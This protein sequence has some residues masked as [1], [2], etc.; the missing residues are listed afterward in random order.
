LTPKI[1]F[2]KDDIIQAGLD[3]IESGG[4]ENFTALNIAKK[5]GSSVKPIYLH[6][7][8]MDELKGEIFKK[9]VARMKEYLY[10]D[11][12]EDLE[13]LNIAI[14]QILFAWDHMKLYLALYL[15]KDEKYLNII[16]EFGQET[17]ERIMKDKALDGVPQGPIMGLYL[18]M[19]TYMHGFI[20]SLGMNWFPEGF[21]DRQ[22]IVRAVTQAGNCFYQGTII[23]KVRGNL[24]KIK[25]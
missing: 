4:L 13:I 23:N 3:L 17:I 16:N 20:V 5:L 15:Q 11:Y 8:S 10:K 22:Q 24:L 18:Q 12:G 2:P 19:S 6:W 25:D 9:I 7:E 14:G 1:K 21:F